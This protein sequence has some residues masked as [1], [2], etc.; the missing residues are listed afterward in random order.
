LTDN[1]AL[2]RHAEEHKSPETIRQGAGCFGTFGS[3]AGRGLELNLLRLAFRYD[4]S[5]FFEIHANDLSRC[6]PRGRSEAPS[7]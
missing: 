7:R 5:Q 6:R 4:G 1:F 3:L 2:I